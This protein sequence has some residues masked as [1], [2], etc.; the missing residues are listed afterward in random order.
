[1]ADA[2]H[3]DTDVAAT[4]DKDHRDAAL[5]EVVD[6]VFNLANGGDALEFAVGTGRIALPLAARG[7][8]VAGIELSSAMVEQL[9]RKE[10][11]TPMKVVLGDMTN[12]RV[13]GEFSLVFLVFNTIDNLLTQDDQVACFQNAADHLQPGGRFAIET[14][15]PPIQRLPHGE[16]L[17][18]FANGSDHMGTDEFDVVTQNYSSHHIR[19][20]GDTLRHNKVPFRYAWPAEFD[21]MAR[22][23]WLTLESRGAGWDKAPV[24]NTSRSHVSGWRKASD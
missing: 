20:Q 1:M 4:Y 8:R 21:L 17:L 15:V 24:T 3:F 22:L 23:A 7:C 13:D 2:N 12:A 9:R 18:A 6:G 16:T 5:D 10:T 14:L 19:R 11:A